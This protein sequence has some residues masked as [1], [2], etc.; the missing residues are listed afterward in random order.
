MFLF[1]ED[2]EGVGTAGVTTM[3]AGKEAAEGEEEPGGEGEEVE[4]A[5]GGEFSGM[6]EICVLVL[7]PPCC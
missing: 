5:E 1:S 4:E 2:D 3:R 6:G 7:P